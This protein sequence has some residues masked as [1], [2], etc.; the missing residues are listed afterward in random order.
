MAKFQT[1]NVL[2]ALLLLLSGCGTAPAPTNSPDKTTM[3]TFEWQATTCAPK[4]FPVR[5]LS[6]SLHLKDGET[7][8]L[9]PKALI[10]NG[11]GE[12]GAVAMIGEDVKP[13]PDSLELQWYSYVERKCYGGTFKIDDAKLAEVFQK[14][15]IAPGTDE[16][17]DFSHLVIGMAPKGGISIWL[18][19]EGVTEEIAHLTAAEVQVDMKSIIGTYP[20]V[21][22]YSKDVIAKNLPEGQ[23]Q[24]SGVSE[25]ALAKW[26]GRYRSDYHWHWDVT[27]TAP[28]R[29]LFA[30]YFNGEAFYWPKAPA[31]TESFTQP[32][33]DGAN[34]R[35]GEGD[36]A[37]SAGVVFDDEELFAAFDKL[38]GAGKEAGILLEVNR[39]SGTIKAFVQD[40]GSVIELKKTRAEE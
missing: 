26:A 33:P 18:S 1:L 10:A 31:K 7:L 30:H 14:K 32:L 6:A 9:Q 19:G 25:D 3:Q 11:W 35:W 20:D 4:A 36:S 22:A 27:A 15:L 5:L 29:G 24:L 34:V 39:V 12:I 17:A 16:T 13:L 2:V 23:V 38:G 40:A 28:V 21:D 37:S 8:P